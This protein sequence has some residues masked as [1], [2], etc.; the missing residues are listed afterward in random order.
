[1][2]DPELSEHLRQLADDACE[3]VL[4]AMEI[5]AYLE[6]RATGDRGEHLRAAHRGLIRAMAT[7]S[8]VLAHLDT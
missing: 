3:T 6:L 7:L 8:G 1:M 5:T 4:L 2:T